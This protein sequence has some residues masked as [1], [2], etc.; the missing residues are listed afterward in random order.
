[1]KIGLVLDDSLDRPDGVQQ[2][3]L[4]LGEWLSGQGHDVTYLCGETSRS[5]IKVRSLSK[6]IN[7]RFNHNRMAI[8]LPAR[9]RLVRNV[10]SQGKFDV[11][12]I[13]LPCSPWLAG[14]VVK[15]AGE[16]TAVIGTF[17]IAPY[18]AAVAHATRLLGLALKPVLKR[19]DD[20]ISVSLAAQEFAKT[21]FGLD[22]SVV[23]NM[24]N[25]EKM[26]SGTPIYQNKVPT[27]VY[28]G[29]LVPRKGCHYL[30]QAVKLLAHDYKADF[31]VIICGD[32]PL[33]SQLV[34]Y[35]AKNDLEKYVTFTGFISEDSK[36]DYLASA[37]IAVFPST[38][39]ESFGIVLIEAMAAG[40]GVVIGGNN[41]GYRTVL[42]DIPETLFDPKD[43]N[44]LALK[45]NELLRDKNKLHKLGAQ[46][47]KHV[48]KFAAAVV[49]PKILKKYHLAI[50]NRNK[51]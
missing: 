3:V 40:A 6:N 7:V 41:V 18:S 31:R 46:Q 44:G 5:D 48:K 10:V 27:I 28:L 43:I 19:F 15:A 38:G 32:G 2:Y 49:G 25:L 50:A 11:L 29:R 51:K 1:M 42:G 16:N 21:S 37:E 22:S 34:Q 47:S 14:R 45:L 20:V 17:H 4:R 39:G 12:H 24:V 26:K 8:P 36:A 23:P 13:Q 35:V 33:K 30:L 9:K